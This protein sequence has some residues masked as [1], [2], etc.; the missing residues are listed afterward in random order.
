MIQPDPAYIH[1]VRERAKPQVG[2]QTVFD[3]DLILTATV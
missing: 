2:R 1:V 3:N